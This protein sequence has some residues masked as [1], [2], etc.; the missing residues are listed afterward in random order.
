MKPDIGLHIR[1]TPGAHQKGYVYW[2]KKK[3]QCR[4]STTLL[5]DYW[6]W[7][8]DFSLDFSRSLSERSAKRT[9]VT[10]LSTL[11]SMPPSYGHAFKLKTQ[12]KNIDDESMHMQLHG[13]HFTCPRSSLSPYTQL[14]SKFDI[15]YTHS[16]GDAIL[17][18]QLAGQ[19]NLAAQEKLADFQ[20]VPASKMYGRGM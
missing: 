7:G 8:P 3:S 19:L 5:F 12:T 14:Q 6:S 16:H 18:P 15:G 9:C 4:P 11:Q 20:S 13:R 17:T 1:N 10:V 2:T